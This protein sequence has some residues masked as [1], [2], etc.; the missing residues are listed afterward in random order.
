MNR[1]G[2]PS[3]ENPDRDPQIIGFAINA[4]RLDRWAIHVFRA[5]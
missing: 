2:L 5:R 3:I 4:E 1:R